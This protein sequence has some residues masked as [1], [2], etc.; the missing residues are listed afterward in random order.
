M[1]GLENG[2]VLFGKITRDTFVGGGHGIVAFLP[3]HGADFAVLFKV[4][5][6][7]DDTQALLDRAAQWHVVNDLVADESIAVDKEKSAVGDHFTFNGEV[8]FFV[9]GVFTGKHVVVVG[10]GFIGIGNER[11]VD[12]LDAS[13]VFWGLEPC[14]VGKLGIGRA[15]DD[16]NV[17][18]FKLSDF[19]LEAVQ[20]CGA[21]EGEILRV[22]KEDNVF[23]TD[24]LLEAEVFDDG[25]SFDG[26]GAKERGGSSYEY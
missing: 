18:F 16:G 22:E 23:L 3:V 25:F 8:S 11:V 24:V 2:G 26:F 5:E 7:I 9:V 12:T 4:L 10:D 15:A 19:L 14:P 21:D 6:G 1:A 13:F 17:A 20:F